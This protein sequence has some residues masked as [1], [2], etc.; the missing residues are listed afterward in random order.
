MKRVAASET[1][2]IHLSKSV[3]CFTALVALLLVFSMSHEIPIAQ[4]AGSSSTIR[5]LVVDAVTSQPLKNATMQLSVT[6]IT[7]TGMRARHWNEGWKPDN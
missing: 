3:A 7:P 5:G 4:S 6:I 2:V 1:S